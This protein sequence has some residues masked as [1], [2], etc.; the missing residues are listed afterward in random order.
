[1]DEELLPPTT[2]PSEETIVSPPVTPPAET[3][4][5]DTG[6]LE[7]ALQRKKEEAAELKA[8]NDRL[9][10]LMRQV[11]TSLGG[12]SPAGTS[13]ADILNSFTVEEH[14]SKIRME[15]SSATE[16]KVRAENKATIDLI[17]QEAEAAR[18]Q[19]AA[20]KQRR[21]LFDFFHANGG[22]PAGFA[23]FCALAGRQIEIDLS[24][25]EAK[26]VKVKNPDGSPMYDADQNALDPVGWMDAVRRGKAGSNALRSTLIPYN[27]SSGVGTSPAGRTADGVNVYRKA[28]MQKLVD[29]WVRQG[30]DDIAEIKKAKW[31]D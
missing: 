17:R 23:D 14:L 11:Q 4:K 19:L 26:V 12:T 28:D 24:G 27:Q 29:A 18:Q 22:E 6:A 15:A 21:A 31:I 5:P 1:M 30:I 3:E 9:K 20:E 2:P 10:E 16:A 8:Q 13:A 25:T 7:R